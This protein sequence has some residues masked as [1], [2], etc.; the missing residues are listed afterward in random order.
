MQRY[1]APLSE[2]RWYVWQRL[3]EPSV[4]SNIREAQHTNDGDDATSDQEYLR[5]QKLMSEVVQSVEKLLRRVI[6]ERQL[7]ASHPHQALFFC[8]V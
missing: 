5:A 8:V 4:E 1:L 2:S 6:P 3:C 7:S